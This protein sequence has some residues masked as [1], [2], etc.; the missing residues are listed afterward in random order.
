ME[1]G[2][3][4]RIRSILHPAE[5]HICELPRK[6]CELP[7]DPEDERRREDTPVGSEVFSIPLNIIFVSSTEKFVSFL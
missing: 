7:V 3:T 5:Y 2:Q 4:C 1:R 6:I